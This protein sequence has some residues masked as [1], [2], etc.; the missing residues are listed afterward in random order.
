MFKLQSL[1]ITGIRSYDP[2]KTSTIIFDT[3][4]TLIVGKNGAGKTTVVECLKFLMTGEVPPN[5]RSGAFVFD[6]KILGE[7]DIR[8]EISIK[9]TCNDKNYE[10]FR[11][12]SSTQKHKKLEQKTQ[13]CNFIEIDSTNK[14]KVVSSKIADVDKLVSL[15]MGIT[16][17]ILQNVIFCHQ[18]E[19]TWPLGDP[20]SLKKKLD[21]IFCSTKYS[22]ALQQ[23]KLSRKEIESDMK[24]KMQTLSLY[25]KD[26]KRKEEID[27]SIK[28]Y[29]QQIYDKME[30]LSK[31]KQ[32]KIQLTSEIEIIKGRK[33]ELEEK[34]RNYE[35]KKTEIKFYNEIIRNYE[36][37]ENKTN[38]FDGFDEI[39]EIKKNGTRKQ[40][41]E[42]EIIDLNFEEL[43]SKNEK[44]LKE[45]LKHSE[46]LRELENSEIE[47]GKILRFQVE[48]QENTE[49]ILKEVSLKINRKVEKDDFLNVLSEYKSILK[50]KHTEKLKELNQLNE[51][52]T[53]KISQY[54]KSKE[55]LSEM[56]L[57]VKETNLLL[58]D[59]NINVHRNVAKEI[60]CK[61]L[62][63]EAEECDLYELEEEY[64]NKIQEYNE[65]CN[66]NTRS[67]ILRAKISELKGKLI[68]I[69]GEPVNK[70]FF[71]AKNTEIEKIH[72]EI[73]QLNTE[74]DKSKSF[75]TANCKI[76]EDLFCKIN[77]FTVKLQESC[78]FEKNSALEK[79]INLLNNIP[80]ENTNINCNISDQ[81][82]SNKLELVEEL[83]SKDF[84][85]KIKRLEN[86]IIKNR[87][88]ISF[89]R[90]Y[91]IIL[92]EQQKCMLCENKIGEKNKITEKASKIKENIEIEEKQT[93][94]EINNHNLILKN[95]DVENKQIK[96]KN[97]KIINFNG[98]LDEIN[99]IIKNNDIQKLRLNK[100]MDEI[101]LMELEDKKN[102]LEMIYKTK[103]TQIK[104]IQNIYEEYEETQK[105]LIN[106]SYCN[107][108]ISELESEITVIKR[109]IDGKKKSNIHL[110][111]ELT[112]IKLEREQINNEMEKR[113]KINKRNIFMEEIV[114]IE[115]ID[116][117]DLKNRAE[118]A[119]K[120]IA[121][122]FKAFSDLSSFINN[123]TNE[124]IK[125]QAKFESLEG[126]RK[127][128]IKDIDEKKT[129][130]FLDTKSFNEFKLI[131]EES[132]ENYYNKKEQI[133][134]ITEKISRL[135]DFI[136]YKEA[137]E[138]IGKVGKEFGICDRENLNEVKD[139]LNKQITKLQKIADFENICKGEIKQIDSTKV[140]CEEELK[141][142]KKA[143]FNYNKC[144]LEL[145]ILEKSVEDLQKTTV[146]LE[147]AIIEYHSSKIKEL[148]L[149]LADLWAN[150]Y[151]GKDIEKIE[152]K[153]DLT[154]T[155]YNYRIVMYKNNVELDMRGRCSAGQKM[156]SSILFRI[157]LAHA[158]SQAEILALDE[159]T[160]NLDR[161]NVESLAETLSNLISKRKNMQLI[162]IT[163]DEEFVS[164][165]NRCGVDCYYKLSR[166]KEGCSFIEEKSIYEN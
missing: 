110:K 11:A 22:K 98:C 86:E 27:Y 133:N 82:V 32:E 160:T 114:K 100:E 30:I 40:E 90:E 70:D 1:N 39:S 104:E 42:K 68:K 4:L 147:K 112:K 26:K 83:N 108:Q 142:F 50:S 34:E 107:S 63:L 129:K 134:K 53:I 128:L 159:P 37:K 44:M 105:E 8:A 15:Y 140:L 17:S 158:F 166:N 123:S 143:V 72:T 95:I 101:N 97:N 99:T 120:L 161:K 139:N 156:I 132:K 144:A 113:L 155:T 111:S 64:R 141:N 14:R 149:I 46:N 85:D 138:F 121:E 137:K 81:L 163:H 165:I 43:K 76:L 59:R 74:I 136:K 78:F 38:I 162:I 131:F 67:T 153:S 152:L 88:I 10:V 93:L 124:F 58:I 130:T 80:K 5:A 19:A 103:Q 127:C 157:A 49:E 28:N 47:H 6:P 56:K 125:N 41:L 119:Q 94:L 33:N 109:E 126:Q 75:L 23:M 117:S 69:T 71:T 146:A 102:C 115:S 66:K 9:F 92:N 3:P 60:E 148:N 18:D 91:E 87:G 12:V 73:K 62:D 51:N 25:L 122:E 2:R 55:N 154:A 150:T 16:P 96:E 151:M 118:N 7:I 57:F 84:H 45:H 61:E 116:I 79:L 13:E 77:F 21:D 145:K 54:T 135:N 52:L 89:Y 65:I 106:S 48:L 24:L 36:E 35:I 20:T 29:R 164:M 31:F